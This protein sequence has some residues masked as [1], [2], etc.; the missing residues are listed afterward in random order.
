MPIHLPTKKNL[1]QKGEPNRVIL[2]SN[3]QPDCQIASEYFNYCMFFKKIIQ[4]VK[5]KMML[6]G[7]P[8]TKDWERKKITALIVLPCDFFTES[9]KELRQSW[10]TSWDR[11]LSEGEADLKLAEAHWSPQRQYL[12]QSSEL[13]SLTESYCLIGINR[14]HTLKT[15][16]TS[17]VLRCK[18]KQGFTAETSMLVF[19]SHSAK[20]CA[21]MGVK[22]VKCVWTTRRKEGS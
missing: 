20:Q 21:V 6:N 8:S 9:F 11:K 16:I 14:H 1:W 22:L 7:C 5:Y 19:V 17:C 2:A 13:L 10:Q 4:F 3:R 18:T 12:I 15:L